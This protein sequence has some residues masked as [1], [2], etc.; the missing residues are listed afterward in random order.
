LLKKI[1]LL[2]IALY[3]I[4]SFGQDSI[5][6]ENLDWEDLMNIQVTSAGK[7]K[8]SINDA[9]ANIIVVTSEQIQNRGYLTLL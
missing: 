9:P 4:V 3:S 5:I 1:L 7:R 2:F 8:Q 6:I